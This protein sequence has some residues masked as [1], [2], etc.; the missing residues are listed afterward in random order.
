MT[1]SALSAT[2]LP[3]AIARAAVVPPARTSA[4]ARHLAPETPG[5][6]RIAAVED[7]VRTGRHVEPEWSRAL[8]DPARDE[9]DAFAWLGFNQN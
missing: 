5:P 8:H 7:V 3:A 4:G 9:I 1:F 2:W 6:V